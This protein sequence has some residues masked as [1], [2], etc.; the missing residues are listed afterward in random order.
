MHLSVECHTEM[1]EERKNFLRAVVGAPENV[2]VCLGR[3]IFGCLL[4]YGALPFSGTD[5]HIAF[6]HS[7]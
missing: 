6:L 1:P 2:I 5:S 3:G 4:W 7:L